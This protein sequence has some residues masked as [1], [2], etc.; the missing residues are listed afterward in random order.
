MAARARLTY[1]K[2][3]GLNAGHGMPFFLY[4]GSTSE[5][6]TSTPES[7]HEEK[8]VQGAIGLPV[9]ALAARPITF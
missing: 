8:N 3:H 9:R 6:M 2:C 4:F 1:V 5:M 7:L